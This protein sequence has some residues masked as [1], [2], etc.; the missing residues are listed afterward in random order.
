MYLSCYV[1]TFLFVDLREKNS[2]L[3]AEGGGGGG[4]GG[5]RKK[6]KSSENDQLIGHFQN[7]FFHWSFSELLF[8]SKKTTVK[9]V[10]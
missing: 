8:I 9:L 10:R 3:G 2:D 5:G 4:G 1:R 6:K 7:F